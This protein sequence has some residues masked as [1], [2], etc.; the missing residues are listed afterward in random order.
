MP[1]RVLNELGGRI[2][3]RIRAAVPEA[4]VVDLGPDSDPATTTGDVLFGGWGPRSYEYD[5]PWVQLSGTGV[6]K[7]PPELLRGRVVTCARGASAVPISEFVLGAMLAFE[8][9]FPDV[10][11]HEPPEHWN[12]ARLGGLKDRTVGIVGFGGIGVAVARRALPFGMRVIAHRRTEAPSPLDGVEMST[13]LDAMLAASDHVVLAV[14][15]TARTEHL[16]DADAFAKVKPG[17]HLVNIARG[18]LVDQDALRVALDDDRV[19]MAT[20]D[21]VDPEPLPAGHW[22]YEHPKVRLSAHIS[23][24]SHLGMDSTVDLF[25][26][27]LRR[28]VAGEPLQDVVDPAEGY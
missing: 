3:D 6:D 17:V 12:F 7:V 24:A 26:E 21:T 22:L 5:V 25:V 1:V 27:N 20:L 13:S 8:K 10:W 4:D 9:R 15:L 18:R 28:H 23:W 11:L 19:A 14:P 16:L 2:G